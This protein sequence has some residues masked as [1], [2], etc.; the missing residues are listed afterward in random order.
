MGNEPQ[1]GQEPVAAD[2]NAAIACRQ[3]GL[4][5]YRYDSD[6]YQLKQQGYAPH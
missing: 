2:A 5:E 6:Q 1:R 4:Q 3:G